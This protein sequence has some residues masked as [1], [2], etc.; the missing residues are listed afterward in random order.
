[1]YYV[2]LSQIFEDPDITIYEV[3]KFIVEYDPM[4][5]IRALKDRSNAIPIDS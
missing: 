3:M 1:M 5:G 2:P 4:Q